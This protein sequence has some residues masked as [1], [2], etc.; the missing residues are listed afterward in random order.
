MTRYERETGKKWD[1]FYSRADRTDSLVYLAKCR[2]KS[3]TALHHTSYLPLRKSVMRPVVSRLRKCEMD[4]WATRCVTA[5]E[6][7]HATMRAAA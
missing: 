6:E 1:R 3:W 5:T 7:L 4:A 2:S